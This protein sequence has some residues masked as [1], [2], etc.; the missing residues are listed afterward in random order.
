MAQFAPDNTITLNTFSKTY[1]VPGWRLGYAI[2]ESELMKPINKFHPFVVANSPSL[3]QYAIAKFMGTPEDL[4]FRKE[5]CNIM[6]A[7]AKVTAKAFGAID[8]VEV[9]EI[10]GSFYAFPKVTLYEEEE[11]PGEKFVEHIFNEAK[12]VTVPASEFG[13]TRKDHFR[14]SFGSASIEQLEESA[15]RIKNV[16]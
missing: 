9:P 2:G 4:A 5:V 11:N 12:V 7:R 1:C 15:N 3:S 10:K 6:D 16:L 8:G 13:N 14:I